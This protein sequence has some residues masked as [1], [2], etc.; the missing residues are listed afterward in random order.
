MSKQIP[1]DLAETVRIAEL[2]RLIGDPTRVGILYAL[3]E[4]KELCVRDISLLVGMSET[5]V[6][7]ALRILRTARIVR[8][9]RASRMAFYS[10][11]D[12]HVSNLLDLC[13]E[14]LEHSMAEAPSGA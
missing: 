13:R 10:L 9:R 5:A 14:H 4:G 11:D 1:V 6:S 8:R 12:A 2:F 7:H 3:K